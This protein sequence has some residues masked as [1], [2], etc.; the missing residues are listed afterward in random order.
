MNS[1]LCRY[2]YVVMAV[3]RLS[4]YLD[5]CAGEINTLALI[6]EAHHSIH[7]LE[8]I[9]KGIGSKNHTTHKIKN[10]SSAFDEFE[11][12]FNALEPRIMEIENFLKE[13]R[14]AFDGIRDINKSINTIAETNESLKDIKEIIL[15]RIIKAKKGI[16]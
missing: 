12:K 2:D 13:N 4:R 11:R 9:E 8:E 7:M 10:V 16:R 1:R 15:G 14:R 6:E 5:S 3:E